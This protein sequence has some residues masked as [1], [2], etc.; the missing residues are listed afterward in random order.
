MADH[1]SI[2]VKAIFIENLALAFFLGMCTFL[3]VSQNVKTALGL[4]ETIGTHH[5]GLEEF[6]SLSSADVTLASE[7]RRTIEMSDI[8][9]GEL[10][11]M[12]GDLGAILSR[13]EVAVVT[14]ES[15][16]FSLTMAHSRIRDTD[17]AREV[18][19][20]ARND[21]VRDAGI[22]ILSQANVGGEVSLGLLDAHTSAMHNSRTGFMSR[23]NGRG[24]NGL[25]QA[26]GGFRGAS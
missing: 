10:S 15:S 22:S 19:D 18:V 21:I 12:R 16:R 11:G 26:G 5:F 23:F 4:G 25:S 17:L 6:N 13:L 1:L 14:A 20:M 7:A 24:L 9:I 8:A 3:A 2:I